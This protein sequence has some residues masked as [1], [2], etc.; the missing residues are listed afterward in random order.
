MTNPLLR[1]TSG[2]T[3]TPMSEPQSNKRKASADG[4]LEKVTTMSP[5]RV[6]LEEHAAETTPTIAE[7][8]LAQETGP[9]PKQEDVVMGEK[10]EAAE[11]PK[12]EPEDA[13]P[14][15]PPR[16]NESPKPPRSPPLTRRP[17]IP[18]PE[19]K[20]APGSGPDRGRKSISEQEKKRGQRLFGG[21]LSTLSGRP[22][23]SQQKKRADIERRQQ[24]RAQ[25]QRAEDDK[26]RV[27]KLAK[28]THVR[29]IEQVKF[30]E[31][32]VSPPVQLC[33]CRGRANG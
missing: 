16:R 33:A 13:S 31:Q 20:Q 21:L 29:K 1:P 25:Q 6:K 8:G 30:D 32:V 15:P 7:D 14:A 26:R 18:T 17:S 5:K 11:A 12:Q 3:A 4:E 2:P 28:L 27:E 23:N 19:S 9:T 24:E 10:V 22:A